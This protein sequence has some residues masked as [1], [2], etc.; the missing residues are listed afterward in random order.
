MLLNLILQLENAQS[1]MELFRSCESVVEDIIYN[2]YWPFDLP[3]NCFLP[4][5][6]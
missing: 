4:Y 2:G 6:Q 3:P 1:S 5:Y